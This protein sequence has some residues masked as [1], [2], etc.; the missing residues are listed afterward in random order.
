MTEAGKGA[1]CFALRR[2]AR[3]AVTRALNLLKESLAAENIDSELV[4]ALVI[5]AKKKI[6]NL[7]A[8]D[9][10]CQEALVSACDGPELE[11][12]LEQDSIEV[13]KYQVDGTLVLLKAEQYIPS[14]RASPVPGHERPRSSLSQENSD[15]SPTANSPK[16][17]GFL[18]AFKLPSYKLPV[19]SGKDILEFP[20]WTDSFDSVVHN[21]PGLTGIHKFALLKESVSGPAKQLVNS[22]LA[23]EANYAIAR[24]LLEES[25]GD[26]N[27]LL[28]L[29]VSR[30][31]ALPAVKGGKS[32]DLFEL[33]LGFEQSYREIQSLLRKLHPGEIAPPTDRFDMTSYFLTPHLLS[34]VPQAVQLRWFDR[35]SNP[36]DR[37]DFSELLRFLKNTV[38]SR[39]TCQFLSEKDTPEPTFRRERAGTTT[40]FT[41]GGNTAFA[42]TG[43]ARSCTA[44]GG[45]PHLLSQCEAFLKKNVSDRAEAVRAG[46]LCYNCLSSG[47]YTGNC[48]SYWRCRHCSEKHHSLLCR[49][50]QPGDSQKTS[51]TGDTD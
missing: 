40:F 1:V 34:K 8:L 24:Q 17:E 32:Q 30:L 33:I 41:N 37:Y 16:A 11:K 44:C 27:L 2:P 21:H 48:Q 45:K 50:H 26:P 22:L 47:H 6:E 12:M 49:V 23:T 4:Q 5:Q 35:T 9:E 36:K 19:F 42:P 18:G 31:H 39:Q 38:K 25:Y 29:F 20:S 7:N 3:G 15:I 10:Q 14:Q 13:E 51:V 46:K 28:G 43:G